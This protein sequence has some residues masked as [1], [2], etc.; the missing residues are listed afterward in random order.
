MKQEHI[1]QTIALAGIFQAAEMVNQ[2]ATHGEAPDSVFATSIESLFE[3]NPT[4]LTD[5]YGS[6]HNLRTGFQLILEIFSRLDAKRRNNTIRYVLSLIHLERQLAKRGDLLE[7]I[8]K[9][10]D[11]SHTQREHFDHLHENIIANL[12]GTYQDTLST[13]KFRIQVVGEQRYL[14]ADD[15]ASKIRALLLAGI[16]SAM[17]WQQL[18]GRRWQLM[19]N[20]S[21]YIKASEQLLKVN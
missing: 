16:R 20:K 13:F 19:F 1:N 5:V 8:G 7:I 18:G 9:R 3:L 4:E 21:R 15:I 11:H 17:L 6:S 12:A 14:R 10:I 2:L